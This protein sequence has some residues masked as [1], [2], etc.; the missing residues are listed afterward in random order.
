[1]SQWSVV[2]A[3]TS[4]ELA[5]KS[6]VVDKKQGCT[7]SIHEVTVQPEVTADAPAEV[8]PAPAAEAQ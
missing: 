8:V 2:S 1:M 7:Y 4:R 5:E 6:I 3:Y